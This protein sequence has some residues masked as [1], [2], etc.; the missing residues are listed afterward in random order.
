MDSRKPVQIHFQSDNSLARA[1]MQLTRYA[2]SLLILYLNE[3]IRKQVE[4][5]VRLPF[6]SMSAGF[7]KRQRLFA[8]LGAAL[9]IFTAPE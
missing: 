3:P 9:D 2:P 7:L 4:C 8:C 5:D 6:A 1:V